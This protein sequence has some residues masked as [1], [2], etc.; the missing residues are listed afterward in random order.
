MKITTPI[1]TQLLDEVLLTVEA[2]GVEHTIK[3]LQEAKSNHLVI[4]DMDVE[5]ILN[6]VTEVTAVSKERILYGYDR[7]DERKMAMAL[8]VYFIKESFSYSFSEIKKIFKKDSAALS[9]YFNIAQKCPKNPK[10]DFDKK[11]DSYIKKINLLLTE[12]KLSNGK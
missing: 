12:K 2:I 5:F 9:R 10:S 6:S 7:T 8:C 1:S 11:L 3:T 4:G